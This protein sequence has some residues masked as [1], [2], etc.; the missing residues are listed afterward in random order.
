MAFEYNI[1]RKE[2]YTLLT[3]SGRLMDKSEAVNIGVEMEEA[4]E[5]G[6]SR[7][8]VDLSELD[9][10]NST[11]L[12]ILINLVN[13]TSDEGGAV[14]IAGAQPRIKSLFKVTKLSSVFTMKDSR[15]EA[16]S[17]LMDLKNS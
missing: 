11:G 14:V 16:V 15:E 4:L 9:Y 13:K 10:M 8:I 17:H 3:M 6:N 5:A 1:E 2:D 12:N 7:F